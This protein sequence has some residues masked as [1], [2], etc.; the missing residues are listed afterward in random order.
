MRVSGT[1]ISDLQNSLESPDTSKCGGPKIVW[2]CEVLRT[3]GTHNTHWSGCIP[4]NCAIPKQPSSIK[5]IWARGLSRCC[6]AGVG[7]QVK[8]RTCRAGGGWWGGVH[9]ATRPRAN[10]NLD[11]SPQHLARPL[12]TGV[13]TTLPPCPP[14]GFPTDFV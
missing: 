14:C 6:G 1:T 8:P 10:K 9:T 2:S 5:R 11:E 12:S 13:H 3:C 4:W 7:Q